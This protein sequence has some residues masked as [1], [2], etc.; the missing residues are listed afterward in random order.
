ML[1]GG[2]E[3]VGGCVIGGSRPG[4]LLVRACRILEVGGRIRLEKI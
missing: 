2:G 3:V 4:F 1:E